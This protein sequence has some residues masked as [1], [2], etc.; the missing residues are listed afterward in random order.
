MVTFKLTTLLPLETDNPT[1]TKEVC[2]RSKELV[3]HLGLEKVT[4]AHST[5]GDVEDRCQIGQLRK[6]TK[7]LQ[8]HKT[9]TTQNSVFSLDITSCIKFKH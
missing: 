8:Q 3:L 2:C 1:S 7:S 6:Q 4:A 5:P 9:Y